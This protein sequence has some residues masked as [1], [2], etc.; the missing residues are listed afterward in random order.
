MEGQ[1]VNGS[2][3][4]YFFGRQHKSREPTRIAYSRRSTNI[5]GSGVNTPPPFNRDQQIVDRE[6]LKLLA[7]FHFVIAGLATA[8]I[9]FLAIHFLVMNAVFNNPEIWKN[10]PNPP[11][12]EFFAIFKWFYLVFGLILIL[13]AV[14]NLLSGLYIQKRKHRAFSFVIGALNC[15]QIPFGTV[16]GVFTIVVLSRD[17]VCELYAPANPRPA[18]LD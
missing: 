9:G 17:S 10:T 8:G 11:P 5:K 2:P 16:L 4:R 1:G 12:R 6:H 13:A 15:L 14:G 18:S 3:A 7:I